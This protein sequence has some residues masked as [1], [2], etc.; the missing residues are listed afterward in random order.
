MYK[1]FTIITNAPSSLQT[2]RH[3]PIIDMN[4]RFGLGADSSPFGLPRFATPCYQM[5]FFKMGFAENLGQWN[6]ASFSNRV[7][8]QT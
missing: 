7:N 2:P 3:R 8:E 6:F 5:G 1:E 4:L